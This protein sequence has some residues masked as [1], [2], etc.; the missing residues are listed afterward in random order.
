ML[1]KILS[2]S[3]SIFLYVGALMFLL[4]FISSFTKDT[5]SIFTSVIFIFIAILLTYFGQK[6]WKITK[7]QVACASTRIINQTE[8]T[9]ES[10]SQSYKGVITDEYYDIVTRHI[11]DSKYC[12]ISN[13]EEV[14]IKALLLKLHQNNLKSVSL[15]RMST[16]DISVNYS[17]YP[18]GKVKLQG[19]KT[20]MQILTGLHD[21]N[22]LENASLEEY[23]DSIDLWITYIKKLKLNN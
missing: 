23:I 4:A 20:W 15:Q 10:K 13:D 11:V 3:I 22:K 17:G 18:I 14:F 2:R 9:K 16:K 19:K 7:K 6:L 8:R 5:F 21:H 1:E 12:N